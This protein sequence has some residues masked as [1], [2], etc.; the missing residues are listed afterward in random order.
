INWE[1]GDLTTGTYTLTYY[2]KA[3]LDGL[4]VGVNSE[5]P[6]NDGA[7]LTYTDAAGEEVKVKI[8]D[9][10]LSCTVY[11]LGYNANG[12]NAEGLP[13]TTKY[14]ADV[15][16]GVTDVVPTR[17]GYTFLGWSA[18]KDAVKAE[19][20]AESVV[21]M[22]GEDYDIVLYA[23]W[24]ANDYT[25]SYKWE[26]M[27]P[28]AAV[29]PESKTEKYGESVAVAVV[30]T[31]IPD[32]N[33]EWKFLGWEEVVEEG[34]EAVVLT[35]AGEFTMPARDIVFAGKWQLNATELDTISAYYKIEHYKETLEGEYK[36][37][38]E[39][40][41]VAEVDTE[42]SA[43]AN[44]YEGYEYNAENS[45]A[46][47]VVVLPSAEVGILTLKLYYDLEEY[48]ITYKIVG[49]YFADDEYKV[50]E[51]VPYGTELTL[52]EDDMTKT[53]YVWSGWS[54]L[55]ETMPAEDVVVEGS[56]TAGETEYTVEHYKQELDGTYPEEATAT[57]VKAGITGQTTEAEAKNYE[58]F[59]AQEF[60]QEVIEADGTTVVEIYYTRNDYTITYKIVGDYFA[61]E[62]YK[63]IEDVTYGTELTLIEDD[64]TKAGYVWSGW[65][66][67]PETMP[68]EDVVVE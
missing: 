10:V 14:F 64:M 39:D 20:P 46:E 42:V 3:D 61:N 32:E 59:T 47:G 9:P 5:V 27:H 37:A 6:T 7:V 41:A 24:E 54:E 68:A 15:E 34:E 23:V 17:E 60:E 49:D 18:D 67:L 1:L 44:E 16:V 58:G 29:L 35:A 21:T 2:V 28:E 65:S 66:E 12:G 22:A 26:G 40:L 31:N 57:E 52:I 36:F 19:Y 45:E 63:V 48:T 50:I 38:E 53:G 51:D 56:Y 55:P 4:D 11:S 30:P 62:E 43:E 13:E 33:G 25:V 8:E